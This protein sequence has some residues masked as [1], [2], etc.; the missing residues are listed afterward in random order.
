MK[1]SVLKSL[2]LVCVIVVSFAG[3]TQQEPM[4]VKM[5]RLVAAENMELKEELRKLDWE[6]ETQK[7]LHEQKVAELEK[8]IQEYKEKIRAWQEES[9]RNVR[10]QVED[11]VD[12]LVARNTELQKEIESLKAE[13]QKLR[14]ELEKRG[15]EATSS[16]EDSLL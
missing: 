13:N 6:L 10:K 14:A 8:V 16:D 11:V 4:S 2:V 1:R 9:R 3:C 5:T 12:N 15:N 7:E